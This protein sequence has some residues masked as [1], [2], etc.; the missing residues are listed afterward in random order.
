[1]GLTK[2]EIKQVIFV[3]N[4]L[5]NDTYLQVM[6]TMCSKTNKDEKLVIWFSRL[7]RWSLGAFFILLGIIYFD[8][9]TWPAILFGALI[10]ITGFFKP[11]RCISDCTIDHP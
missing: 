11:K 2:T 1:M 9:G 8:K 7:L 4:L 10:L 3:T 6:K 5:Y